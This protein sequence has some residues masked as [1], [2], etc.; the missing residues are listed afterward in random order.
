MEIAHYL[1]LSIADRY[2][3]VFNPCESFAKFFVHVFMLHRSKR[4][5]N[6]NHA[7]SSEPLGYNHRKLGDTSK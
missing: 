2:Q 1:K 6:S 3:C 5:V 7:C 4:A